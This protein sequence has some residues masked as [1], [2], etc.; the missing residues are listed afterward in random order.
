[1]PSSS[2]GPS[3]QQIAVEE[4]SKRIALETRQAL[5]SIQSMSREELLAA[6]EMEIIKNERLALEVRDLKEEKVKLSLILEEEDERRAN[7]FLKKVEELEAS[8]KACPKCSIAPAA[9]LM[10]SNSTTIPPVPRSMSM[11]SVKE[12]AD[13]S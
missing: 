11:T 5:D 13:D 4:Q 8:V 12:V 3:E 6:L 10:K 7:M 2:F 1:M 9:I